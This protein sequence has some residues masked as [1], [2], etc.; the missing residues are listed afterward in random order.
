MKIGT[1]PLKTMVGIKRV[2]LAEKFFC[3]R[4]HIFIEIQ[5]VM[6]DL[7]LFVKNV[8]NFRKN[9]C[10]LVILEYSSL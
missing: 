10:E 5:I 8:I 6:M 9:Q 1:I 3:F 2:P 4:Q 7:G